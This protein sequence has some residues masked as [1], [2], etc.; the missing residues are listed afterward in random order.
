M[1]IVFDEE[2]CARHG[3]CVGA[4]PELFKFADDGSLVVI[5]PNPSDELIEAAQDAVDL[6]P[7]QAL[8]LVED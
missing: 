7:T 4:A 6:C 5:I 3:Q 8:S 1:R 2:V